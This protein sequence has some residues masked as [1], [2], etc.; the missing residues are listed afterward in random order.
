MLP[1]YLGINLHELCEIRELWRSDT[2]LLE[3]LLQ[4]LGEGLSLSLILSGG[5]GFPDGLLPTDDSFFH[6]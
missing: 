4:S 2:Q 6:H 3:L 1:H 5:E